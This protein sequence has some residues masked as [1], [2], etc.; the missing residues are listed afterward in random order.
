MSGLSRAAVDNHKHAKI[1]KGDTVVLSSR[2]I[3]GNE[4]RSTEWWT[5]CSGGRRM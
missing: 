3:P 1:E 5:I 2:I 4:R